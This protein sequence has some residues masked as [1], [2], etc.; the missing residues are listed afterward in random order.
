MA[1]L[2]P[3]TA[4]KTPA[5]HP[6]SKLKLA[7]AHQQEMFFL[8]PFLFTANCQEKSQNVNPLILF[9]LPNCSHDV[10]S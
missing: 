2:I 4:K 10:L 8:S 9:L 7:P 3:I 1:S 6:K 5:T